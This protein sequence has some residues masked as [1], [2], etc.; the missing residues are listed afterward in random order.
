M[1]E[2]W[3]PIKG[4]EGIYEVSNLG[5]IRSV[6][7]LTRSNRYKDVRYTKQGRLLHP[8]TNKRGYKRATLIR[9]NEREKKLVHRIVAETF[10]PNPDNKQQVN[11]IDG[12]KENNSVENLEW[13][14]NIEN[15]HHA[16]NTGLFD[17]KID[18]MK[19]KVE[20]NDGEVFD[21]IGEAAKASGISRTAVSDSANGKIGSTRSMSF[22]FV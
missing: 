1:K 4:Y 10:I 17:N 11:H 15:I 5:A 7:R 12:N 8:Y 20:R 3:K 19:K 6:D 21:S 16:F 14:S 22:K 9:N 2:E 18:G 13:C